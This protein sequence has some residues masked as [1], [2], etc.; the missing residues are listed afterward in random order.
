MSFSYSVAIRTLGRGGD[1]YRRE[2]ESIVRQTIQP[3][4]VVVYIAE[5]YDI[6]QFRIGKEEYVAVPKG[7]VAQR[8][9]DYHE[10]GSEYILLLDDDV[11]L[12]DDGVETLAREMLENNADVIAA[13]VFKAQN[14]NWKG[15]VRDYISSM[16][17][18]EH[19]DVWAFRV[20]RNASCTYNRQPEPRAYLSQT[21][22]GPASLWK[23]STMLA[24]HYA[25][26]LW[27]DRMG[28]AWGDDQ[29]MFYKVFR[30]G[31]KLMVSYDSGIEHLDAKS[32]STGFSKSSDRLYKRAMAQY[33]LWY[34]S[35]Y[36]PSDN[37]IWERWRCKLNFSLKICEGLL[38]HI[39]YGV[40]KRQ[41]SAVKAY[42][43]GLGDGRRY[44]HETLNHI[45]NY[46]VRCR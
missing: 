35:C 11:F 20:L 7:M 37:S 3:E 25:D 28:F 21:A 17:Y 29:L 26:E 44:A 36:S 16:F 42:L 40:L 24:I 27:L 14:N 18:P 10:I 2:L 34:R 12:P 41:P 8:A 46:I 43:H 4:K 31:F 5:G 32:A 45:P 30:N 33:L 39:V 1:K 19:S 13:D 38:V 15:V 22:G 23:K 6:P 9:L